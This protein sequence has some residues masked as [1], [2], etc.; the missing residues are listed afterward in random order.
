MLLAV[1]S[2]SHG[3]TQP[4][5]DAV[6]RHKPDVA[7]HLGD[8][9][10]DCDALREAFPQLDIRVVSG[11]CDPYSREPDR[12]IFELCGVKIFMTHGHLYNVKYGLDSL[13]NAAGFSGAKLA[14]F[15]HTHCAR[16]FTV[17][18]MDVLNPGAAN[19]YGSFA[20]V[21]LIRGTAQ[22]KILSFG[23]NES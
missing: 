1:F 22:C 12:R 14:L 5:I 4:M 8:H 6:A 20:L 17:G 18:S 21:E 23:G 10:R 9:D 13:I 19:R 2:D 16:H 15:G 11:N 3:A 7:L